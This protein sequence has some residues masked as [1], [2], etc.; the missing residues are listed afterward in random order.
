MQA[1]VARRVLTLAAAVAA[2]VTIGG[3]AEAGTLTRSE[4]DILKVMNQVRA[5]HGMRS[6]RVDYRLERA[7]RGHSATMLRTGQFFH[8]AF[9]TR[10]RRTGVRDPHIGE[11]LAWGVGVFSRARAIVNT[12]LESPEHRA[13]LLRAGYRTVG[14]GALRGRFDG[15]SGALVITADFAGR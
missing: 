1:L 9:T 7:A 14:V 10:I 5:A 13:N 6:L 11:N 15:Y 8:G 2:A 3:K 12:W 4:S